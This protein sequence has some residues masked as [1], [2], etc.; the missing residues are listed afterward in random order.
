M[1]HI[2]R[3]EAPWFLPLSKK[4]YKWTVRPIPGPHSVTTS[5]PLA[6]ILRDYLNLAESLKEAKIII[7]SGKVLV[8]GRVRKDY[9]YPIGLMDVISVPSSDLYFRV[10]PDNIKFLK[11][12][13]ITKDEANY[14]YVRVMNKTTVRGGA[15]QL[16]LDDG[17]NILVSSEEAKKIGTLSTLKIEIPTQKIVNVYTINENSYVIAI[18]GKNIGLHGIVQKISWSKYK[19]RKYTIVT[20]KGKDDKTFQTNLLNIMSIGSENPDMRIE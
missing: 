16:N 9:K 3:F 4:E 12:V 13:K 5:V 6:I 17:R 15:I 14:K 19:T 7:S 11:L 20:V 2:T 10:V 1:G 18:G 8:D